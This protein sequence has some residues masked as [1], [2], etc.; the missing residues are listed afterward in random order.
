MFPCICEKSLHFII[1]HRKPSSSSLNKRE[2]SLFHS[3]E[4]KGRR[5]FLVSKTLV[6]LGLWASFGLYLM[7]AEW[8]PLHCALHPHTASKGRAETLPQRTCLLTSSERH[9]VL[10]AGSSQGEQSVTW[11]IPGGLICDEVIFFPVGL[12]GVITLATLP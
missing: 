2:A 9:E 6:I 10:S 3:S 5:C 4:A 1:D 11:L 7:A 12:L 8:L